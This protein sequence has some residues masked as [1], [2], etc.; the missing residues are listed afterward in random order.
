MTTTCTACGASQQSGAFCAVCGTPTVASAYQAPED[1]RA[2][3]EVTTEPEMR[4]STRR[5]SA[6]MLRAASA[7]SRP[8]DESQP[9]LAGVGRRAAAYVLDV[10]T[11]SVL[12]GIVGGVVAV[13]TGVPDAMAGAAEATTAMG[14]QAAA[15]EVVAALLP[16]Y[17]VVGLVS[18][19]G[20]VGLA[21]WEGTTGRTVGNSLLGIRTVAA[22][23]GGPVGVGRDLL[24]WLVLAACGVLP[25]VGTVLVLVSP[26][27]DSSGR[28]QGWHDK[29]ARSVVRDV[30]GV[31]PR[32]FA[33][34][35]GVSGVPSPHV[36]GAPPA[37]VVGGGAPDADPWAFPAGGR[38]QG[39]IIT[40]IPGSGPAAAAQ[41]AQAPQAPAEDPAT[42]S[43]ADTRLGTVT[44]PAAGT[45]TAQPAP[46]SPPSPEPP[47]QAPAV[48]APVVPAAP[49][50]PA[51]SPV[52]PADAVLGGAAAPGADEL[53]DL[54][55]T[56]FSV[57]SRRSTGDGTAPPRIVVEVDAGHRVT[58]ASR[59][60][61]GRNPQQDDGAPAVLLRVDDPSRSVSKT[62]LELAPSPD[63]L[64]V[65]DLGS[66][67]GSA[68]IT[69][70]GAVQELV[71]GSPVTVTAGWVVQAGARRL[72]V[73]GQD[74][75]A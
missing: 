23:G 25:L 56:R 10:V 24:R 38:E 17:G 72:T 8:G 43:L 7:A 74:A 58:V 71:A 33:P 2:R 75:G 39:G 26:T 37:T 9:P 32:S 41:P 45:S 40:G 54:E 51:P 50:A 29:A 73:V 1:V 62:H 52:A 34:A 14:A 66:T 16:V 44:A 11:L 47:S 59:T 5:A 22:D 36:P 63:G 64:R 42:P 60:L 19:L 13:A 4:E 3:L 12:A 46:Q 69:P 6:E 28:R 21:A 31:A 55:A 27:F 68:V 20:W 61:V 35:S 18:L 70:G 15:A 67:N 49:P 48:P 30:R 65:T 57:S 53:E